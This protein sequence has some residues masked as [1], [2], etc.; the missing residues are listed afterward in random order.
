M[1]H[2]E[3][4]YA[5]DIEIRIEDEK[6]AQACRYRCAGVHRG[7]HRLKAGHLKVIAFSVDR[8]EAIKPPYGYRIEYQGRVAMISRD[9]RYQ[10]NVVRYGAAPTC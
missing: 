3:A 4:A 1:H 2:L 10:V 5:Q 8:G 9:T 6:L 7:R